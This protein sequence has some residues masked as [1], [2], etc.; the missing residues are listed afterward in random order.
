MSVQDNASSQTENQIQVELAYRDGLEPLVPPESR[1]GAVIG[2]GDGVIDGPS[3]T[4]KV[5][6][7]SGARKVGSVLGTQRKE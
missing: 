2:S 6:W 4:G 5:R 7:R 1:E 3:L